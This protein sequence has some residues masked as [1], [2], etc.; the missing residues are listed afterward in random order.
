MGFA[1]YTRLVRGD[2]QSEEE[3]RDMSYYPDSIYSV[4]KERAP[5]WLGRKKS[6]SS[7]RSNSF[8][9]KKPTGE[10]NVGRGRSWRDSMRFIPRQSD[11]HLQHH[12]TAQ[13]GF[14]SE[15]TDYVDESFH[16]RNSYRH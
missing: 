2:D 8:F 4:L 10:I 13:T 12:D 7:G 9:K 1:L 6:G 15:N 14:T 3:S 16:S 5:M 11:R